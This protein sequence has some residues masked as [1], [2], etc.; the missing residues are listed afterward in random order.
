[1]TIQVSVVLWTVICFLLLV[2]ILDRLLF[3]P[4][5]SLMDRRRERISAAQKKRAEY[6]RLAAEQAARREKERADA[7]AQRKKQL[8]DELERTRAD[9]RARVEAANLERARRTDGYRVQAER[10]CA[11]LLE[12][13]SERADAL[14]VSFAESLTK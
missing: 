12:L 7:A 3:R 8:S 6:E 11:R 10:D 4:V 5:L 13:L 9:G 1:M 14:A 2:L